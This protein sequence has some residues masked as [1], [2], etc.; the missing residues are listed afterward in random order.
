MCLVLKQA[1][2]KTRL[3]RAD[4]V[5]LSRSSRFAFF[6]FFFFFTFL[7]QFGNKL[8]IT[9]HLVRVTTYDDDKSRPL[10]VPAAE[11]HANGAETVMC[12][13]LQFKHA[14]GKKVEI[15]AVA[16]RIQTLNKLSSGGFK[17]AGP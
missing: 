7:S 10:L 5:S 12:W 6:C 4:P 13:R 14:G 9:V 3:C 17:C 16:V 11:R 15:L 2:H 1:C 8:V